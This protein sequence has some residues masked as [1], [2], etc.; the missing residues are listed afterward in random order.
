[1]ARLVPGQ[2]Q[3]LESSFGPPGTWLGQFRSR[4][5]GMDDGSGAYTRRDLDALADLRILVVGGGAVGGRTL[6]KLVMLGAA[7]GRGLIR[8]FDPDVGE[9]SNLQRQLLT[10]VDAGRVDEPGHTPKV[11]SLVRW[12]DTHVPFAKVEGIAD[13]VQP[14]DV[15]DLVHDVDAVVMAADVSQPAVNF[16]LL[17][18][19]V[20]R[21][22]PVFG[23]LDLNRAAVSWHWTPENERSPL[24]RGLFDYRT[25]GRV[26]RLKASDITT[27][28]VE[29]VLRGDQIHALGWIVQM[30]DPADL[31]ASMLASIVS[32]VA[33]QGEPHA[34]AFLP[35]AGVAAA[36]QAQQT[37]DTMVHY[38]SPDR[39]GWSDVQSY[40][41]FDGETYALHEGLRRAA[42][43]D[44]GALVREV[45]AAIE[46]HARRRTEWVRATFEDAEP[47]AALS[48]ALL[49]VTAD[50]LVRGRSPLC[51]EEGR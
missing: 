37:A 26:A 50:E 8:V 12:V 38:F 48:L 5:V 46:A 31:P 42:R 41:V 29:A 51:N 22:I 47:A 10:A 30:L 43:W 15:E 18:T 40:V 45:T 14:E 4:A 49:G 2:A 23:G 24:L 33:A 17:E 34:E 35:Q 19:C 28:D 7:T 21:R 3:R 1:M 13:G 44:D 39:R 9:V 11:E 6:G 32:Y 16:T 36:R 27:T 25:P 20:R